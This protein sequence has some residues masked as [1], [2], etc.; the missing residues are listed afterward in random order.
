MR[1]LFTMIFILAAFSSHAQIKDT[2]FEQI[3]LKLKKAS[4][5]M[6]KFDKQFHT[7]MLLEIVGGL[8]VGAG[9]VKNVQPLTITGGVLSFFGFIINVSS[10]EHIKKAGLILRGNKLVMPL[11]KE[12]H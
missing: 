1:K 10:S 3:D 8:I 9:S 2:S 11:H 7:G 12:H 5:E 6:I 4:I